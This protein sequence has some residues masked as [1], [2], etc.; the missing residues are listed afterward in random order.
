MSGD[1]D[2]ELEAMARALDASG[3]YRV[4]RR[5]RP[6][7]H[8]PLGEDAGSAVGL[9]LDFETTGF[10]PVNDRI[11]Q[12]ALVP[13]R[14]S[15][16][17]G[18]ILATAAPVVYFEDPGRPLPAEI[19]QLT[20]ITD[21]DVRGQ[22]I[23]EAVVASVA[24]AAALVIAH[25]ASFDRPFAERRMP[26][27]RDRPWACS[28]KDVPWKSMGLGSSGLEYLLMKHCGVFHMGH[29]ADH[30]CLA[31]LHLLGTPFASG[32]TPFQ[33]LLAAARKKSCRIWAV[34]APIE[35]KDV[36][37]QRGYRWNNGSDGRPKSWYRDLAQEEEPAELEWLA[38][39]MYGGRSGRCRVDVMD[40]RTRYSDR[41]G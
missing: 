23:D 29:R 41:A 16:E 40:A 38:G 1:Y 37:K 3:D 28:L 32:A 21:E 30:D 20:G 5:F 14:Y 4:L 33:L 25:N 17:T 34:G 31:L 39:A 9:V 13:F 36:L 35:Q 10:D 26:L 22:R 27:F 15:R 24:G 7:P 6:A 2:P 11:I 12:V 18:A 8:V 19:V